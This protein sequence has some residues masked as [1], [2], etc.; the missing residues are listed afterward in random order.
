MESEVQHGRR[1][2]TI[3]E[4][5]ERLKVGRTMVYE[6]IRKGE[7]RP[8]HIGR[9]VRVEAK[10]RGQVHRDPR[11]RGRSGLGRTRS[12][13]PGRLTR[14]AARPPRWKR[15]MPGIPV[16]HARVYRRAGLSPGGLSSGLLEVGLWAEEEAQFRFTPPNLTTA[17]SLRYSGAVVHGCR[18]TPAQP[19]DGAERRAELAQCSAPLLLLSFFFYRHPS[20]PW[21][22]W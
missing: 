19:L 6:L 20:F 9:A 16:R 4:V 10:R 8:I 2:L 11:G 13:R 1:L 3:P 21:S 7:I 15:V 17:G 12:N 22:R 5:A 18:W 14:R